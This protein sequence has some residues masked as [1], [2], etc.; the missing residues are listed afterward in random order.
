MQG[1]PVE[2][3]AP[4]GPD[5]LQHNRP[6]ACVIAQQYSSATFVS[7]PFNSRKKKFVAHL[8]NVNI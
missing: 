6:T 4:K 3:K 2:I 1:S 8:K 5:R 7:L